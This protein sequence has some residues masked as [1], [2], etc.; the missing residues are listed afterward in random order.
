MA[1]NEDVYLGDGLYARHDGYYIEFI[2]N[3][4]GS[5]EKR[6]YLE[7][8]GWERLKQLAADAGWEGE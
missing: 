1:K 8:G 4:G 7:P 2:A 6:V 5:D 3:K